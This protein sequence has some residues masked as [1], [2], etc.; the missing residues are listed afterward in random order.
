M[1]SLY[2]NKIEILYASELEL[3]DFT[4]YNN[5]GEFLYHSHVENVEIL[6]QLIQ[7]FK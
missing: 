1:L 5:K 6:N 4:V 7:E 2:R 3:Y